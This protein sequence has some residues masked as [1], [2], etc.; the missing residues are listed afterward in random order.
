MKD[1][2]GEAFT[3]SECI[4]DKGL[5]IA[6]ICNHCPYVKAVADR[7]AG[8]ARLLMDEGIGVLAVM[9]NDYRIKPDDSPE[10]MKRFAAEHGFPFPY[11]VDEGQSVGKAYGAVCTPDFFGFNKDG[12]LQYRGRLDSAGMGDP[13]GRTP[14][15]VNAMRQIAETGEGPREQHPSMGC[16]IKWS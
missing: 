4:T 6:F 16:S 14:E 2:D 13:A 1:P 15:L 9:S 11:L 5:L 7:L 3:M 12:G 10:N 8:D